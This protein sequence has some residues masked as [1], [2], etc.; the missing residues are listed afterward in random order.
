MSYND[1]SDSI[2]QMRYSHTKP[3]GARESWAEIAHRVATNV[4]G[5]VPVSKD[6]VREIER[7]IAERKFIP[8]GRFLAQAGRPLH[9]TS[10][11]FMYRAEDTREGWGELMRKATVSLMAGGGIGVDYSDIRPKGSPLKRTGG[12]SSGMPPLANVVNEIGRGVMSGGNRRSAIYASLRWS[13]QDVFDFIRMKDWPDYIK[14]QKAVDFDIPAKMDMTNISV[15]LD[16]D[17]FDAYE[18]SS[19]PMHN[20]AREVYWAVVENM[21]KTAEPGFQVD[22]ANKRESLRNAC[23][24]SYA[25]ILTKDGIRTI[26]DIS[27]GDEIWSG[28]EWT[29]VIKK[30]S[31]GVKPVYKYSTT[32]GRF[33]GTDD[34]K[35]IS[36]GERVEVKDAETVDVSIGQQAGVMQLDPQDIMDGLVI[37]DGGIHKAS[38]NLVLLYIGVKD[39]DYFSSEIAPLITKARPGVSDE[40][41][42][43]STTITASE[44]P[45]TYVRTIPDRFFYGD[46][47]RK[48]GFL[49]GLFTANGSINGNR[50]C[51]KQSSREMIEQVQDMLSSLGIHSYITTNKGKVVKFSNGE[52]PCKESY[53]INITNGRSIFRD[54]IGF[55]QKYKQ[56]KIIGGSALQH[57]TYA[58]KSSEYIEDTEVFE[59]TVESESHTYWTGCCLVSNCTEVVSEDDADVCVLGSVNM[60]FIDSL[61]EFETISRLGQILLLAGTDYT[62]YPTPEVRVTQ[63]KNRRTGSGLMGIHEWLI[64][65]GKQYGAD[66]ELASWLQTWK[67]TTRSTADEYADKWNMNRPVAVR[68]IAPNGSIS[69][70]GG[71]TTSGIEP[72]FAVSYLRRFLSPEGWKAQY[73]V[74]SVAE[75]LIKDGVDPDKIEDAYT[76]SMDVERRVS[77]QSF[78]QGYVDNAISSTVNLPAWGTPG[79]DDVQGFGDMIYKYLPSLRGITAYPDACR[80]GQPLTVVPFREAADKVGVVFEANESCSNG[81]CGL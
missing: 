47:K 70:A 43:I 42:E 54:S 77:F 17:F 1:F 8:G 39:G 56:D 6:T 35:V 45:K 5:V 79:N 23:Q 57:K 80:S 20:H 40:T 24:P 27:V 33:I 59:I 38:N 10:N 50:V 53:D 18:N 69:I 51:L 37:G 15:I 19:S 7:V 9:M 31:T 49:R 12:T 66:L 34:H 41:H 71:R 32:A 3:D 44:L 14:N 36:D 81:V 75:R 26:G 76:L 60:G 16:K 28:K 52:Y 68:A 11:C 65:R 21:V 25:T 2:M 61:E 67:D 74:D 13:H 64:R 58:V 73:V 22:Y 48:A 46:A 30:W 62:D 55:I 78:V 63:V 29:K 72:I 4:M